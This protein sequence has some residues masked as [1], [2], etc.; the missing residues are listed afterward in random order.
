VPNVTHRPNRDFF[1]IRRFAGFCLAI[2]IIGGFGRMAAVAP[3]EPE[4]SAQSTEIP[5][6]KLVSPAKDL[7]Y[8]GVGGC[9]AAA[10]HGGPMTSDPGRLWN[11]SYTIWATQEP[12]ATPEHRSTK[13]AD[14]AQLID[15]HNRA[16]AV[17]YEKRSTQILRLLDHLPDAEA[18]Q[19]YKDS[20]CVACHSVPRDPATVPISILADGVGCEL[21][22]GPAKNWLARHTEKQWIEDY[23]SG[24]YS[25]LPDMNDTRS[26]LSRARICAGCHVGSPGDGTQL[27]RDVN[28]DLI[29]AGHP[30]LDFAFHAFLGVMPKHWPDGAAEPGFKTDRASHA[31]AWAVGQVVAAEAALKLLAHHAANESKEAQSSPWPEFSE[32]DCFA[33]HHRLDGKFPSPRQRAAEQRSGRNHLGSLRW[34]TWYFPEVRFLIE[35]EPFGKWPEDFGRPLAELIAQMDRSGGA[36]DR[37]KVQTLA[38]RSAEAM[39]RLADRLANTT[40]DQAAVDRLLLRAADETFAPSVWDEAAERL[41]TLDALWEAHLFFQPQSGVAPSADE[42]AV[43]EALEAIREKL[44]FPSVETKTESSVEARRLNPH[45]DSPAHFDPE[46]IR[47]DAFQPAFARIHRLLSGKESK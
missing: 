27:T 5:P 23:H 47:A 35:S 8:V 37:E 26:L 17:L 6:G 44:E 38:T 13:T 32:Y 41:L 33:C 21:C 30:R 2:A 25:P 31:D 36:V 42:Q 15:K 7:K 14:H 46:S 11:C 16:Y 4:T 43:S 34:G 20:R 45:F 29:A 1:G 39:H 24:K 40:F 18:A 3:A 22:H 10:C 12:I 19:P 9:S 28:H